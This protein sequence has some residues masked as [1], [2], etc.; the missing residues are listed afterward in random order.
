[1]VFHHHSCALEDFI[2]SDGGHAAMVNRAIAQHAG[3]AIRRAAYDLR[4]GW[5]R[6][7]R[8][9]VCRAEDDERRAIESSS[10]MRRTC[11]VRDENVCET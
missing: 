5:K 6:S 10:D 4:D 8:A 9:R 3:R 2:R 11:V 7:R 1:M